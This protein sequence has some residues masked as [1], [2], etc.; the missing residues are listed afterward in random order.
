MNIVWP[1]S[2]RGLLPTPWWV[3]VDLDIFT[4]TSG[5]SLYQGFTL[6]S[7]FHAMQFMPGAVVRP[8]DY[9]DDE[10][11]LRVT[12][13]AVDEEFFDFN[14][15][16]E[17]TQESFKNAGDKFKLGSIKKNDILNNMDYKAHTDVLKKA[18]FNPNNFN[19][20]WNPKKV[21]SAVFD[22]V[23]S[24]PG[25]QYKAVAKPK[26]MNN[27]LIVNGFIKEY[28]KWIKDNIDVKGATS[29]RNSLKSDA[30]RS[31]ARTH[32]IE[33]IS[34][35]NIEMS[36]DLD[37]VQLLDPTETHID[38]EDAKCFPLFEYLSM[39]INAESVAAALIDLLNIDIEFD[40]SI[41]LK[42]IALQFLGDTF[43]ENLAMI[44][45]V[46]DKIDNFTEDMMFE[47]DK[48]VGTLQELFDTGTSLTRGITSIFQLLNDEECVDL[49]TND[50][51]I[52]QMSNFTNK[53]EGFKRKVF[54]VT[55]NP[56]K[57]ILNNVTQSDEL[58]NQVE[59]ALDIT[60]AVRDVTRKTVSGAIEAA[61]YSNSIAVTVPN[62]QSG[63][64]VNNN[65]IFN[66][67][68]VDLHNPGKVI[69][70]TTGKPYIYESIERDFKG[71]DYYNQTHTLKL[72]VRFADEEEYIEQPE[73]TVKVQNNFDT[74][75]DKFLTNTDSSML[76]NAQF[77]NEVYY[78]GD[79]VLTIFDPDYILKFTNTEGTVTNISFDDGLVDFTKYIGNRRDVTTDG[80]VLTFYT[81]VNG[82]RTQNNINS[83]E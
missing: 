14:Q 82:T 41:N 17:K 37:K 24:G 33:E 71:T 30:F 44:Q 31:F 48:V 54:D 77:T 81:N 43:P 13:D 19:K 56:M 3:L 11:F 29:Y 52:T 21:L 70:D 78:T 79:G 74:A 63:T 55:H 5:L 58:G 28:K 2:F 75:R 46:L 51:L 10:E 45:L 60:K 12:R 16:T 38:I 6:A 67:F 65:V 23:L 34:I 57:A 69:E 35:K 68:D 22:S 53:I 32:V 26:L 66:T 62:L 15:I 9:F 1:T 42:G 18:W 61:D 25:L 72:G 76:D 27:P 49:L 36:F 73:Y 47:Y 83:N 4:S 64:D 50:H 7:K 8:G 80:E 20:I 39:K 59:A 40:L